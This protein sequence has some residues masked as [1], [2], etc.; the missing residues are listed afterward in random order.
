MKVVQLLTVV[1][2]TL[3]LGLSVSAES[4]KGT[5][6]YLDWNA[7]VITP[8]VEV[9]NPFEDMSYENI[10]LMR[11]YAALNDKFYHDLM[12][13]NTEKNVLQKL[14]LIEDKL[15]LQDI[16]AKA[17]Y[18]LRHILI[19]QNKRN[20]QTPNLA[21]V[22]KHWHIQGYMV[23]IEFTEEL[24]TSFFLVPVA[25]SCSHSDMPAPNQ[26]IRVE[27]EQGIPL[28]TLGELIVVD[29]NLN[30]EMAVATAK[31]HDGQRELASL[32]KINAERIESIN[33]N[34]IKNRG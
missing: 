34:L 3:T 13:K 9:A 1:L 22:N 31:Y 8:V 7:L 20:N 19:E 6:N 2:I 21:V 28:T 32:Y 12:D 5:S 25:D 24:V 17:L 18:K 15:R 29:G 10:N 16:D 23:P 27:Y 26:I 33:V 30:A 11:E 4:T 14:A